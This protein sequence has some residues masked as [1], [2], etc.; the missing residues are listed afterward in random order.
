MAEWQQEVVD[1]H[2]EAFVRGLIHSDGCRITNRVRRMVQGEWKYYDYPRYHFTNVSTDIIGIFTAALDR[3]GIAWKSHV[4][5]KPP[6]RD[7]HIVSISR[8]AAVTRM[9]SFVGPKY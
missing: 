2:P 4:N 5:K 8:K 1:A 7:A 6:H 3:L 9:D